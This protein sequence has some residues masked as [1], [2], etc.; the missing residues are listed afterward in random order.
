[1]ETAGHECRGALFVLGKIFV[2]GCPILST[3]CSRSLAF[4]QSE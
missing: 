2:V 3:G 1:M 4:A